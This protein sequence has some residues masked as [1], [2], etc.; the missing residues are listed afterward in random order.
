M[1]TGR[2]HRSDWKARPDQAHGD[3]GKSLSSLGLLPVE[4]VSRGFV[5]LQQ[6]RLCLFGVE[7]STVFG[8]VRGGESPL[9]EHEKVLRDQREPPVHLAGALKTFKRQQ[10]VW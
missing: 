4:S 6:I 7:E 9:M 8:R 2:V 5:G 1:Q 10:P 3:S